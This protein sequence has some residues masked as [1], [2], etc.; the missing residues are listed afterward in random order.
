MSKIDALAGY[1][2][3]LTHH[4]L[5]QAMPNKQKPAAPPEYYALLAYPAEAQAALWDV[6]VEKAQAAHNMTTGFAHGIKTNQASG[7]PIVGVDSNAI[8]VRAASQYAP[9]IYDADGTLL[10]ADNPAHLKTIKSKF[11]A[12]CKV[13]AIVTPYA[14][15]Y[16]AQ[17]PTK[18]GVSLNLAG[19]MFVPSDAPKLSIGGPDIG[20]AFKKFAQPGA[21]GVPANQTGNPGGA[22]VQSTA[23]GNPFG[24]GTTQTSNPF[25]QNTGAAA[26]GANPFA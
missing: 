20:G 3:I 11:H 15:S 10:R 16:P 19:I 14:W 9:E 8:M 23:Q 2:A 24:N 7:K 1:E 12:G 6:L 18:W 5:A 25:Q 21:G 26:Q 4:A 17:N 13:R 22:D